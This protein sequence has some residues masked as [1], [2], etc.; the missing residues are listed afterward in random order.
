MNRATLVNATENLARKHEI[1]TKIKEKKIELKVA[2]REK[3]VV[4]F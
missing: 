3:G 1:S 2:L 4:F